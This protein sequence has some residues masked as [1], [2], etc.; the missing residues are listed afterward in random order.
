MG[1]GQPPLK[2]YRYKI[3]DYLPYMY[4]HQFII[5]SG[6][7]RE[8]VSYNSILDPFDAY[9]WGFSVSIIIAEFILLIVMQNLWSIVSAKPNPHDYIYQGFGTYFQLCA[10]H[11]TH[12]HCRF[13]PL[14][15]I[16]T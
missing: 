7:P 5:T 6:Q 2:H 13:S 15:R 1:I 8:I 4:E 14:L 11:H 9:V 10:Y 12:F 3:V 16:Y